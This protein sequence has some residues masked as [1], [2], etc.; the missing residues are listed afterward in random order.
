MCDVDRFVHVIDLPSPTGWADIGS[1][2]A[3]LACEL[4][5]LH[6][7]R[8]A[9]IDQTLRGGTQ[10][11]GDLFE[12]GHPLVNALKDRIAE[13]VDGYLAGLPV[14][15]PHPFLGQRTAGWR[16]TDSWSSRLQQQGFHTDP[17][18]PHGWISSVY[19]VTVP[20][21]L[22]SHPQHEDWLQFGRPDL[23]LPGVD[24]DTLMQRRVAP[25][26]GRLLLF[27]SMLWHGTVPFGAAAERLTIAFDV[28]P[29]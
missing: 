7:A 28:V 25:Q 18:H 29:A 5:S 17:V 21:G 14:E 19:Y 20:P 6:S 1:F 10:T 23:P 16:F 15:A 11:L 8:Q 26:P 4:R 22:A 13:A 12:Q 3:A 24:R 2:N 27:P 9:P